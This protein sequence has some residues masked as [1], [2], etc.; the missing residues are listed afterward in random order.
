ML[1]SYLL[2]LLLVG[3][4]STVSLH[5]LEVCFAGVMLLELVLLLSGLAWLF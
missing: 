5:G 3:L 1:T 4:G 2:L